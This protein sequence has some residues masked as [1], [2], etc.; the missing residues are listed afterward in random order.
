MMH[1]WRRED[2]EQLMYTRMF[3]EEYVRKP[4]GKDNLKHYYRQYDRIAKVLVVRN[5]L[6]SYS[7][8]RLFIISLPEKVRN[9]VLSKQEVFSG[10]PAGSVNYPKA[11]RAVKAI[12][13][14]EEVIKHFANPSTKEAEMRFSGAKAQEKSQPKEDAFA[15][16]TK[17]LETLILPITAAAARMEAA[18]VTM[19]TLN[20]TN[21]QT[22][23][24]DPAL[25]RRQMPVLRQPYTTTLQT[26]KK[27]D[28]L[29]AYVGRVETDYGQDSGVEVVEVVEVVKVDEVE[30]TLVEV[31]LVEAFKVRAGVQGGN[32]PIKTDPVKDSHGLRNGV[33]KPEQGTQSGITAG[34]SREETLE[35]DVPGVPEPP[36]KETMEMNDVPGVPEPPRKETAEKD[37]VPGVPE[38]PRKETAETDDVPGVPEPHGKEIAEMRDAPGVPQPPTQ[39]DNKMPDINLTKLLEGHADPLS[40]I[41]KMQQRSWTISWADAVGLLWERQGEG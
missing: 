18:A 34:S 9:K 36:G 8:G 33:L 21:R 12:V 31:D 38:P 17:S 6:D 19:A 5:K 28:P 14:T 23:G 40:V 39:K 24:L 30:P 13:E 20:S 15:L 11:L 10:A 26:V 37:D 16:L 32:R 4:R 22:V 2:T 35:I 27:Q 29:T 1:E 41:D 3:L 7:Q 25:N